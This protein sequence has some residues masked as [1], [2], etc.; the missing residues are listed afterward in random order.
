MVRPNELIKM[1]SNTS[2]S[3]SIINKTIGR[4]GSPSLSF[5]I[6]TRFMSFHN[7]M[8]RSREDA[9]AALQQAADRM[10]KSYDK[11]VCPNREYSKGNKVYLETTNLKTDR[12]AKKLDDKR[13]SPFEVIEKIGPSTYKL[14][15]PDTWPVIHPTFHNSYLTPF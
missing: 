8:K 1:S 10:K 14:K 3:S 6:I 15:L 12:L 13:F 4:I 2:E 9:H 5:P 7:R 11:H